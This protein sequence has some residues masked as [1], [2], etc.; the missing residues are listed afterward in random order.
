MKTYNLLFSLIL[1]VSGYS[2][3]MPETM[4]ETTYVTVDMG[5]FCTDTCG[6][7]NHT[8][9][10][11]PIAENDAVKVAR[12]LLFPNPPYSTVFNVHEL[13]PERLNAIHALHYAYVTQQSITNHL[14]NYRNWH[15]QD[16]I[17]SLPVF[18][19]L[20][21]TARAT[22]MPT[23]M[24]YNPIQRSS[25]ARIVIDPLQSSIL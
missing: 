1:F 4:L 15:T 22:T 19:T 21:Q 10:F 24:Q 17:G 7:K 16:Y 8:D 2:E 11:L 25:S 12:R 6:Q 20:R 13:T 5:K 9:R 14:I 18:S 23:P 3:T